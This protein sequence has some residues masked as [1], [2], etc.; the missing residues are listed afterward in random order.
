M[1][2]QLTSR[3]NATTP[4]RMVQGQVKS[5]ASVKLIKIAET[6]TAGQEH[7]PNAKPQAFFSFSSFA[8]G[9]CGERSGM[10]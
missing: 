7:S 5:V 9:S 6:D 4:Y 1:L 10:K 8:V 2:I 3:V